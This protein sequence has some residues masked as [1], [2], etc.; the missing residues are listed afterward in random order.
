MQ[1]IIYKLYRVS[2]SNGDIN[3]RKKNIAKNYNYIMEDI[4]MLPLIEYIKNKGTN[5]YTYIIK[6]YKDN[7]IQIRTLGRYLFTSG[8]N[9]VYNS[10]NTTTTWEKYTY[11]ENRN[12]WKTTNARYDD[13]IVEKFS[14]V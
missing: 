10:S 9:K 1:I 3:L 12:K 11:D 7:V 14:L 5:E 13:E 8:N 4:N 6:K 2:K